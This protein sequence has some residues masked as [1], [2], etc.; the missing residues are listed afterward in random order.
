MM[1]FTKMSKLLTF[2][3]MIMSAHSRLLSI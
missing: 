1:T 2:P 3:I